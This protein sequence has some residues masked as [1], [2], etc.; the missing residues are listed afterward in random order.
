VA[1]RLVAAAGLATIAGAYW[2]RKHPSACP[3]AARVMVQVPHPGISRRRLI[4]ALAPVPGERVL[5]IGPGTGHYSLEVASRLEDGTLAIFDLQQ[6]FLDHTLRAARERG[7][8]NIEPS[9]GDARS[10]P[11][12]DG[13]FDAV[14]LVT[15]LGEIPGEDAA[16]QEVHRVLAPSGRLVIGETALGDPHFVSL[17]ALRPRA[18]RAGLSFERRHGSPVAYFASFRK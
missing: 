17:G 10:L 14:Y 3:Y 4:E 13:S 8:V 15:V 16:L 2:A 9:L 11:Y 12:E 5:E 18:E 6:D 7:L 1:R